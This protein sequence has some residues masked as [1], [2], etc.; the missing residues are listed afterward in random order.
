MHATGD[1]K[2]DQITRPGLHEIILGS[3]ID[4]NKETFQTV[5]KA[6]AWFAASV[7]DRNS[8]SLVGCTVSRIY[9]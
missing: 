9:I 2:R 7:N 4:S 1:Y 3:D 8:Y 6:G 5:V